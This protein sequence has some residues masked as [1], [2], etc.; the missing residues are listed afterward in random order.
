M[1]YLYHDTYKA[2]VAAAGI[3]AGADL[4][5]DIW[6]LMHNTSTSDDGSIV[7]PMA[8]LLA[9]SVFHAVLCI[10][11]NQINTM[12]LSPIILMITDL[13]STVR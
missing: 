3:E 5:N 7:S 10:T 13:S 8:V 4:I 2:G 9:N 6:G 12:T 11:G 1:T